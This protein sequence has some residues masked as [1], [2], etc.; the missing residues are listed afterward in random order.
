MVK[1][2]WANLLIIENGNLSEL[3]ARGFW[4]RIVAYR[5]NQ[6]IT[7]DAF[8]SRMKEILRENSE[9]VQ[10]HH[11]DGDGDTIL[12]ALYFDSTQNEVLEEFLKFDPFSGFKIIQKRMELAE[13]EEITLH[14]VPPAL[15]EAINESCLSG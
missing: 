9:L 13:I 12:A 5:K 7:R 1:A 8:Q 6:P 14:V 11:G 4:H 15:G 2:K 3:N 10:I